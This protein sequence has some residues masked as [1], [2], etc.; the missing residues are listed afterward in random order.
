MSSRAIKKR[1]AAHQSEQTAI[2]AQTALVS[3]QISTQLSPPDFFLW[4]DDA[5]EASE[6]P[7]GWKQSYQ[8]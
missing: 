6:Q 2:A 3:A 7:G 8:P 5:N 1:I 4:L